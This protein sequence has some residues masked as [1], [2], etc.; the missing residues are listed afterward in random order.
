MKKPKKSPLTLSPAEAAELAR[1]E[2]MLDTCDSVEA[3]VHRVKIETLT[4]LGLFL[5]ARK[6]E[7]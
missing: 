5:N 6:A 2:E 7:S 1:I 3:I 4:E